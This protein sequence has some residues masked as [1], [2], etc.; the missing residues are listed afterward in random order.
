MALIRG[1]SLLGFREL[2]DDLGGDAGVLL[3]RAHL[4]PDTIGD[5]DSFISYRSVVAAVTAIRIRQ[6]DRPA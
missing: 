5:H 6:T 1:T 3:A 4:D 2:V